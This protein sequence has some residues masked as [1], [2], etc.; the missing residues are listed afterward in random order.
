MYVAVLNTQKVSYCAIPA[1]FNQLSIIQ[2]HSLISS[3]ISSVLAVRTA[4]IV[5]VQLHLEIIRGIIIM[6]FTT[7][8]MRMHNSGRNCRNQVVELTNRKLQGPLLPSKKRRS[9]PSIVSAIGYNSI[10][11]K[12]LTYVLYFQHLCC[13]YLHFLINLS[14]SQVICDL[15]SHKSPE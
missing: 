11:L 15:N 5:I 1:Y 14:D 9:S 6:P 3:L 2:A 7:T 4:R 10:Y 8:R 13:H 12:L